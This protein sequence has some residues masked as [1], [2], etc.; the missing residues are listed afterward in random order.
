MR[1]MNG[2]E[3]A[4]NI[5]T[6]RPSIPILVSSGYDLPSI[7]KHIRELGIREVLAKPVERDRLAMAM[8]RAL[9]RINGGSER[10]N[11]HQPAVRNQKGL[12]ACS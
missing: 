5:L 11:Q 2:A 4:R 12:R 1:E 8:A 6:I 9:G 3:L 10:S 7:R